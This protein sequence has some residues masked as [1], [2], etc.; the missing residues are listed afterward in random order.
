MRRRRLVH[1]GLLI[2]VLLA[3]GFSG[4]EAHA[5]VLDANCPGPQT[6]SVSGSAPNGR[7]AQ[8]FIAVHTGTVA[9]AQI[10]I[11][12]TATGG[13]FQVQILA[14]NGLGPPL[15]GVLGSATIPDAS[16]PLGLSTV[17]ATF[18][19]PPGVVAGQG[20]AIVL[21]RPGGNIWS[22]GE[23]GE[24]PCEGREFASSTQTGSWAADDPFYDNV[25]QLFVNPPNQFTIGGLKGRKLTLS[26]PGPGPIIVS[27]AS[28]ARAGQA[29]AAG[30]KSLKTISTNATGAGDIT[31][32]LRLTKKAKHKL[33]DKGKLKAR[34][35][36][37]FTPTGGEPNTQ[38]T[39]VKF[40]LKK[41]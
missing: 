3:V 6:G 39:K 5:E 36:I 23:R 25:F 24:N 28:T 22:F 29:K 17:D 35:A 11:N 8:T 30:K 16:V 20:Y 32:T 33:K 21:T 37:T 15:N 26:V 18:S 19:T 4:S 27:D 9:R 14:S 10:V 38:T 12:K 1:Q 40:K 7:R 41:G 2:G 34:A 13:D 31:V